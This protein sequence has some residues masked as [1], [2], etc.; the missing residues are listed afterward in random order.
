MK[1][2]ALN[3]DGLP[4]FTKGLN[5]TFFARQRVSVEDKEALYTLNASSIYLNPA[6]GF[7][8]INA[9][10]KT[11]VLKAILFSIK[12]LNNEPIN[13]IEQ[14]DI[15]GSAPKITFTI[16]FCHKQS[17]YELRTEVSRE[18]DSLLNYRYC[19][20]AEALREKKILLTTSKKQLLDFSK[21]KLILT[22]SEKESFLADDT[23]IMISFNREH[24]SQIVL[25]DVLDSTNFN[26]PLLLKEVPTQVLR[27]LDASIDYL[28]CREV[29]N[30][31]QIELKFHNKD[32]IVCEPRD[33]FQYLSSGTIRG[34]R[35]LYAAGQVLKAGGIFV[36]DEIENHFNKELV[37]TLL[38]LFLENDINTKG[39]VLFFSTHYPELL[40]VFDRNDAL[41]R[42]HNDSGVLIATAFSELLSR[43]DV[44]KS[45]MYESGA[46]GKTA[47]SYD[48]YME[49]KKHL[50]EICYEEQ[51]E[52]RTH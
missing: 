51:S 8:G 42:M 2:I 21:A 9:S 14:R 10:G 5:L 15:L 24:K 50:S 26:S 1:L 45:V 7:A 48:A 40:D 25:A 4:L 43:N 39:A 29:K 35:V 23:S 31:T 41:F 17:L 22:R 20:K 16:V 12:L 37:K 36:V 52:N 6:I 30:G 18:Q 47:L 32:V 11:S 46:L 49:F 19:I 27:L 44:K 34:I 3:I 38:R 28:K 33:L 13:H